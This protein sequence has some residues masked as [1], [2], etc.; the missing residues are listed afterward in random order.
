MEFK[1]DVKKI[2]KR[3]ESHSSLQKSEHP[4]KSTMITEKRYKPALKNKRSTVFDF[5]TTQHTNDSLDETC[6]HPKTNEFE[7]NI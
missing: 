4:V 1:R 5:G 3:V 6:E 7:G 2:T